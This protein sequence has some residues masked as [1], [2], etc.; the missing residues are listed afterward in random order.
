M[1]APTMLF[2][3]RQIRGHAGPGRMTDP[4]PPTQSIL[5]SHSGHSEI[6]LK[7]SNEFFIRI[8]PTSGILARGKYSKRDFFVIFC[9][10]RRFA[11][12][13]YV[14]LQFSQLGNPVVGGSTNRRFMSVVAT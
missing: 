13:L 12:L 7:Q 10:F 9:G 6:N 3:E 11:G 5:N 8:E 4:W 2:A 14:K 1:A